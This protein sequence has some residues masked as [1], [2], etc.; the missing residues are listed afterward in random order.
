MAVWPDDVKPGTMRSRKPMMI[1]NPARQ[2]LMQAVGRRPP[3]SGAALGFPAEGMVMIVEMQSI[4]RRAGLKNQP[5]VMF[6]NIV[7]S[8]VPAP[9]IRIVIDVIYAEPIVDPT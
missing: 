3:V 7:I 4:L 2:Y 1:D 8:N 9:R 5:T 6:K